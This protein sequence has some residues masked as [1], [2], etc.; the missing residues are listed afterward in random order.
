MEF[1]PPE[2]INYETISTQS[3]MWSIGVICYVLLS[4]LSPFNTGDNDSDT[5]SNILRA[6]YDFDDNAF[7]DVSVDAKNFISSL[8][9]REKEKRATATT[10]LSSKW[11][12]HDTTSTNIKLSTDKLKKF[13]IRRKWQV[14][15]TI[16]ALN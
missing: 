6:E 9:I 10:C 15:K 12:N 1:I 5:F 14:S 7:N 11:L 8:L 4:G 13:I 2:I 3:D 16:L